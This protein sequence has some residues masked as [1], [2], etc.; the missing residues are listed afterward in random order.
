[1]QKKEFITNIS[2]YID[3]VELNEILTKLYQKFK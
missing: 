3:K 2:G 1:M